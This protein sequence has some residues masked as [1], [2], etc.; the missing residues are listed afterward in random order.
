ML[1]K[2]RALQLVSASL[3]ASLVVPEGANGQFFA[4]WS[5]LARDRT[6]YDG[7]AVGICHTRIG[8]VY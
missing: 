1:A 2:R 3:L 7:R 6:V 8:P 5:V 4:D